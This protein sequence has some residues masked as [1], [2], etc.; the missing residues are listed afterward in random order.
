MVLD[1]DPSSILSLSRVINAESTYD[2][3]QSQ[4]AEHQKLAS[5]GE[6]TY[7]RPKSGKELSA[8]SCFY[9]VLPHKWFDQESTNF[10][11]F[12]KTKNFQM[13][14]LNKTKIEKPA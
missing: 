7:R 3:L 11:K 10:E 5:E 9:I 13:E 1:L 8:N 12:F 6:K 14:W 2:S 4:V